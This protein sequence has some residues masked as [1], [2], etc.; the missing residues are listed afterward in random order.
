[1]DT[2]K[3]EDQDTLHIPAP[4]AQTYFH[5]TKADLKT[6][7]LIQVGFTSNYEDRKLRHVYVAATLNAAVLGA[8]LASGNGRERIYLA[9]ATGDIEDDP[10]VTDKKFP[11][12]PTLSY[13]SEHPFKV[14]GEV[15]VWQ[16]HPP[17]QIKAIKEGLKKLREQG[18]NVILD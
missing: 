13:R 2:A 6:G 9:E 14:V 1:M 5:G 7:D 18:L 17:G 4:F 10:N 16:G 8:E 11:G 12:N 15:T 3:K